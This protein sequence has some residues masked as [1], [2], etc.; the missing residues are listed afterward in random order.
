MYGI[1]P[2]PHFM[3][4]ATKRAPGREYKTERL[5]LRVAPSVRKVI[6]QATAVSGLAAGDLAFEGARRVLE[7][8]EH[9]VLRGADREAFLEAVANP[10]RPARRLVAALRRHGKVTG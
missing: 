10:P 6:E 3:A 7:E 9:W 8:H 4:T 2:Y 5:E 1:M